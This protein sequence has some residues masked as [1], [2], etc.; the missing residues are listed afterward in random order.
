MKVNAMGVNTREYVL[1]LQAQGVEVLYVS[2]DVKCKINIGPPGL[3]QTA[4]THSRRVLA[5]VWLAAIRIGLS[6][7]LPSNS[8]HVCAVATICSCWIVSCN[9]RPDVALAPPSKAKCRHW[10]ATSRA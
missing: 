8:A 10:R 4:A 1:E 3:H 2:D 6:S 7:A 9:M 5:G